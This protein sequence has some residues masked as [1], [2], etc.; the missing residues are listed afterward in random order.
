MDD[1]GGERLLRNIIAMDMELC[2]II[3]IIY[4]NIKS[5]IFSDPIMAALYTL[6]QFLP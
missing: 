5:I 3:I 4:I 2:I 1:A 6:H